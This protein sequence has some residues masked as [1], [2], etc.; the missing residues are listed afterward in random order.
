[1]I[2]THKHQFYTL[3]VFVC[4]AYCWGV[5]SIQHYLPGSGIYIS[6][7]LA[8]IIAIGTLL[9]GIKNHFL[10]IS[11]STL[12]W[13]LFFLVIAIQ[14]LINT[15][16]YGDYLI[17]PMGAMLTAGLLSLSINQLEVGYRQTFVKYMAGAILFGGIFTVFTQLAQLLQWDFLVGKIL[18]RTGGGRLIGNV[19]QVNQAVFLTS[20]A[21]ASIFYFL[22][23]YKPSKSIWFLLLIVMFWLGM[24]VGFSASRGGILLAIGAFL[25]PVL[26]YKSNFKKRISLPAMFIP[27]VFLGYIYGTAMMNRL[28]VSDIS[29]V[30]RMVGEDTLHLRTSLL[31][32]AWLAFQSSPLIGNGWGELTKFG[33]NNADKLQWFTVVNHSHNFIAQVAADLGILGLVVLVGFAYILIKNLK[34]SLP[35]YLALCYSLLMIIG[36]YSLS[37]YPLWYMRYLLLAIFCIAIIDNTS[38]K[39]KTSIQPLVIATSLLVSLGGIYYIVKYNGYISTAYLVYGNAPQS[40]KIESYKKLENVY[41]FSKYKDLMLYT[42]LP[43]SEDNVNEQIELG[44]RVFSAYLSSILLVKQGNLYAVAGDEKQAD[45]MYKNACRFGYIKGFVEDNCN[46]VIQNLQENARQNPVYYQ[47]YLDRFTIWYEQTNGQKLPNMLQENS[48]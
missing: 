16:N 41:G 10:T 5:V 42:I 23:E 32:Q 44:N 19:A 1:M 15:I 7:I 11:V 40:E 6:I 37:E 38:I 35:P 3:L 45:Q 36:M 14:P 9:Y 17:F 4:F 48:N 43:V 13:L 2:C 46:V 33:L 26:F 22:Y 47:P 25:T 29:A 18:F 8:T 12:L 34:F 27:S 30:G 28:L 39:L 31:N 21:I 20:L 24:G